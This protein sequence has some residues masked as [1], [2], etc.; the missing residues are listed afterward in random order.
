MNKVLEILGGLSAMVLLLAAVGWILLMWL[1]RSEDPARL[2]FKWILT[3]VIAAIIVGTAVSAA[4]PLGKFLAV[5]VG[6]IC[7]LILAVIW[8]P[9]II[10]A[11]AS[12]FMNLYLGGSEGP[13]PQPFYSIAQAKRKQGKYSEAAAEIQKQLAKFPGDFRGMLMLAEIQAENLDDLSGAQLT[14]ERLL[15]ETE[16]PVADAALA[17]NRLA[18]WH[19]KF[20]QDP[21]SA[22]SALERI[23]E[24]FPGSEQAYLATQRVAHLSSTGC[25]AA[26]KEPHRITLGQYQDNIGLLQE[27]AAVR[28]PDEDPAAMAARLVHRLQEQPHDDEAREKLALIYADHYQRLDLAVNQLEELISQPNAPARQVA[29]WLNRLADLRI[30]HGGDEMGARD[31]LLRIINLYPR[32]AAAETAKIRISHLPLELRANQKSQVMPLGSSESNIGSR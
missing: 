28:A 15:A 12:P 9:N 24:L 31:A 20:G 3:V 21:D 17:L 5:A 27:P 1:K 14:V 23:V 6:A 25:L 26:K 16:R 10:N 22:R 4:G 13:E 18:D 29:H 8:V 11:V 30:K 7:G 2:V 32:S 19:L